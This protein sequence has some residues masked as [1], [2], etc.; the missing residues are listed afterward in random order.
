MP[1]YAY[2]FQV[3]L[4]PFAVTDATRLHHPLKVGEYLMAGREVV[5]TDLPEIRRDFDGLVSV[6]ASH[7]EFI[8]ACR[9]AVDQ[10]NPETIQRGRRAMAKRGWKHTVAAM[11]QH[12][13]A[14]VRRESALVPAR[15]RE[16]G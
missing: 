12:V 9:R 8:A 6:A 13:E 7:E 3:C 4:A 2:G 11:E 16:G 10:P 1:D 5:S 15:S 14:V